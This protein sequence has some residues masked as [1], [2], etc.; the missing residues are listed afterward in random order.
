MRQSKLNFEKNENTLLLR[1]F[2][3]KY[4]DVWILP[5]EKLLRFL[6]YFDDLEVIEITSKFARKKNLKKNPF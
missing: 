2:L 5:F 3:G 1:I 6:K 4:F